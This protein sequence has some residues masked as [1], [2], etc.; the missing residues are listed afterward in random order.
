MIDAADSLIVWG[1]ITVKELKSRA[2]KKGVSLKR[3][4][5]TAVAYLLELCYDLMVAKSEKCI[6]QPWL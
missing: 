2:G 3:M 1:G 6:Q 5:L 4:Q